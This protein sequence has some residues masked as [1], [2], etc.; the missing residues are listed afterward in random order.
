MTEQTQIHASAWVSSLRKIYGGPASVTT[1]SGPWK[2]G[3][4]DFA[5]HLTEELKRLGIIFVAGANVQCFKDNLCEDP[6]ESQIKYIDNFVT[7]ETWMFSGNRKAF[8]YDEAITSTPSRRA[9]SG[10]NTEWLKIIPELSKGRMHLIVVTQ[11]ESITEKVFFNPTFHIASWEKI[12]VSPRSPQYRK[13]VR[14]KASKLISKPLKFKNLPPTKIIFDPFRSATWRMSPP[15][16]DIMDD[17]LKILFDYGN[18]VS[19]DT[20][21]LKYPQLKTRKDVTN[22]MR[23]GINKLKLCMSVNNSRRYSPKIFENSLEV[24]Q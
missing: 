16:M 6:D 9:M 1:V 15:E 24:K 8:V 23:R 13:M 2:T 21:V 4:T 14:L 11:E 22:H 19:T 3:K 18:G 17:D 12:P 20:I 10:M 5:I 7:L